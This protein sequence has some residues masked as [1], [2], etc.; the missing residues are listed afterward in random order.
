ML[1]FVN[2]Q[3]YSVEIITLKLCNYKWWDCFF[4]EKLKT[5][6]LHGKAATLLEVYAE[7]PE[8]AIT[9]LIEGALW[10][11]A[12]RLV[13]TTNLI[14]C[15][16]L[17][18]NETK[19]CKC[20]AFITSLKYCY[21]NQRRGLSVQWGTSWLIRLTKDWSIIVCTPLPLHSD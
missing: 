15:F 8:E 4:T 3:N 18:F 11:E 20:S 12:L 19:R 1:I 6:R 16:D 2:H 21:C 17:S 14:N 13:C 7:Q 10:D 9:T 5:K